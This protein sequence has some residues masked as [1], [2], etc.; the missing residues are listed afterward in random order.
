M[1]PHS[2]QLPLLPLD[3]IFH[4]SDFSHAS[5]VAF[6]HT[7][8]LS[9]LAQSELS[10][11]HVTPD[12]QELAWLDFPGVRDLLE[13]WQLLPKGSSRG[14]VFDLGIDVKKVVAHGRNP[15]E[16]ILQYLEDRPTDLVVLATHQRDGLSRWVHRAVA[17]PIARRSK[18]MTLFIPYGCSGFVLLDNGDVALQHVLIPIDTVPPPHDAINVAADLVQALGIS[19]PSFTIIH[20]GAEGTQPVVHPPQREGWIWETRVHQGHVVDEVLRAASDDGADLIVLTTQ[21]HHGVLDALRGSTTE[22]IV[23]GAACP[24]LAI[25]VS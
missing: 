2:H 16:A 4:P 25:P 8:K 9:L 24:V 13:R 20:V 10:I 12:A 17:E 1:I 11:M 21:G 15:V 7:L 18:T 19:N 3:R 23:R 22:R 5:E 6:T 14:D